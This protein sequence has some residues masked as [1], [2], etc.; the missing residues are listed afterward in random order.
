MTTEINPSVQT[1]NAV[2]QQ[3]QGILECAA[4]E[5]FQMMAGANLW[6]RPASDDPPKGEQPPWS[7]WPAHCVA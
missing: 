5:V 4:Q 1:A 3:W 2:D 7:A 6:L